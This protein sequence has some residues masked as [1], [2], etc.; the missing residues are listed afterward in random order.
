LYLILLAVKVLP[1]N[2]PKKTNPKLTST[3]SENRQQKAAHAPIICKVYKMR[4][5]QVVSILGG[6]TGEKLNSV[7][8][9]LAHC[10]SIYNQG[11]SFGYLGECKS[12]ATHSLGGWLAWSKEWLVTK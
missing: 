1:L 4:S 6:P 10:L 2:V 9:S 11:F 3:T 7:V 8:H 5:F 12:I